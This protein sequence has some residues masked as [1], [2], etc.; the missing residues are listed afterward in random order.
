MKENAPQAMG[1]HSISTG[2]LHYAMKGNAPQAIG[3]HSISTGRLHYALKG[4]VP[5]AIR[6]TVFQRADCI[7]P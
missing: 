1:A 6:P 4:N 7:T 3:A 5:K 2:R